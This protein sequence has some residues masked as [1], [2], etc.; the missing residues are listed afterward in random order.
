M[1]VLRLPA[2][3]MVLLLAVCLQG[4]ATP[5]GAAANPADPWEGV[6]RKVYVFNERLDEALLQ[7]VARTYVDVVPWFV[8]SGVHHFLGNL[9]D[10]WTLVNAGLQLKGQVAVETFMR[11]A[12]NSTLG[13]YGVLDIAS[14]AGIDKRKEDFGQTLG[15]WGVQPG[16]YLM[17]PLL[18]PS[19]LRDALA[20]PVDMKAGPSAFFENGGTRNAVT[21]TRVVDL[22]AGLLRTGDALKAASLD[23][24]SFVRDAWLQKRESEVYDGNPPREFDYSEP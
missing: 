23:P 6:N 3:V 7:P 8:R 1:S 4:C 20:L 15:H 18:G 11:V 9:G 24:Y 17:L 14:E 16:P 5:S 22:R 2:S 19:T 12:I 10:V 13:I 21:V